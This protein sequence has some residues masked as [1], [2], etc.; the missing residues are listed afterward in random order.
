MDNRST[1]GILGAGITGLSAAWKLKNQGF[2]VEIYEKQS[3]PGGKIQTLQKDGWLV[4]EGPNTMLVRNEKI[5]DFLDELNLNERIVKPGGKAKKRYIVRNGKLHEVPMSVISFL[6]SGLFSMRAK[7]RLLK[8]PF[9]A[10]STNGDESI[11]GFIR[12]RLGTEPLDYAVDPFVSGVYAGDPEKL[13]VKHTLSSLFELEQTYGSIT[14]GFLKREKKPKSAERALIAFDEGLQVL[15]HTIA[16]EL[17]SVIHLNAEVTQ[18]TRTQRNEWDITLNKNGRKSTR[19]HQTLISTL[20]IHQLGQI[21]DD[22]KSKTIV[23]DL[24]SIE[25]APISI[26]A[27]GFHKEQIEHPL[28]GFGMLI[29]GKEPFPMLGSL[30]SS[31]LFSNRAPKNFVLL[32]CFAGGSRNTKITSY[33]RQDLI[34]EI[35]PQLQRLLGI[36]HSPVFQHHY[37]WEQ[38]IPQYNV[39]Y[40]AYLDEIE[41]LE[42]KNPG[43]F[44][45]GNFRGGV[46]V[47]D[48]I[49]NGFDTAKKLP[50]Y[51][52]N[53]DS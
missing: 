41:R 38:A 44:L 28:D 35:L 29:P 3:Q 39:G 20:P 32:T 24:Q 42:E 47:P 46:S 19:K 16:K 51:L 5:W 26:L 13:S 23:N 11:A 22:E 21:L 40:Q 27:L 8:E 17:K 52:Q 14:K 9:A 30:F 50:K 34:E 31:T 36:E 4:E 7:C 6:S 48:C 37:T 45:A 49:I 1:V 25:Y 12:R 33:S 15:P 2:N 18:I 53:S 43:L 10:A